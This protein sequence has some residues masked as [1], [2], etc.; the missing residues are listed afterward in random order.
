MPQDKGRWR[1]APAPD[2]R[3]MPDEHKPRPPHRL[4][5]FWIVFLVLLSINWGRGADG[6]GVRAAAREGVFQPVLPPPGRG[7]PG[8]VDLLQGR[9]VRRDIHPQAGLRA[10]QPDCHH[11]LLDPSPNLLEQRF[12]HGVPPGE[13]RRGQRREPEHRDLV[14]GR[15]LA[16]LRP[17]PALHRPVL[18]P[19]TSRSG[20]AG[21]SS[22]PPTSPA[23]GRSTAT[24]TTATPA[25]PRAAKRGEITVDIHCVTKWSKLDT[26]WRGVSVDILEGAK[27]WGD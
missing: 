6:A 20:F 22:R 27:V 8:E 24:T 21:S 23:S 13:G 3:G 18:V 26:V 4:P 5:W 11:A 12:A 16:R 1:V 7:R 19:R 14:V 15:A 17:D 25:V 2:G 9:H 10:C